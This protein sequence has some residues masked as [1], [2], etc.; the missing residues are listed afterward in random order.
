MAAAGAAAAAMIQ[1]IKASGVIVRLETGEFSKLMNRVGDPLIV[2]AQGGLH[3]KKRGG[4]DSESCFALVKRR[5]RA[6]IPNIGSGPR[7]RSCRL[8]S[9]SLRSGRQ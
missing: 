5:R 3:G 2:I 4:V 6:L 1:A 8:P 9:D 7:D